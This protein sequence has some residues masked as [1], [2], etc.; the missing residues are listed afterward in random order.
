MLE[1]EREG[2]NRVNSPFPI[3]HSIQTFPPLQL[4]LTLRNS[5]DVGIDV[6]F[7]QI[8]GSLFSRSGLWRGNVCHLIRFA[9]FFI[10]ECDAKN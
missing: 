5:L 9:L 8:I 1:R 10:F 7:S 3:N 6:L 4:V 2:D